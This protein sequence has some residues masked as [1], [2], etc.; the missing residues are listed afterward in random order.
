MMG[1]R[2]VDAMAAIARADVGLSAR[3]FSRSD[4]TG[5]ACG[6]HRS[7]LLLL[8]TAESVHAQ[9]ATTAPTAD[10]QVQSGKPLPQR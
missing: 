10:Q 9:G 4:R 2:E 7:L 1:T 3:Q 8:S 6:Q 5:I